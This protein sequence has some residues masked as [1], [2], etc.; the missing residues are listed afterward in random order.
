MRVPPQAEI[1]DAII[2]NGAGFCLQAANTE[3]TN[4]SGK[5][6][7]PGNDGLSSFDIE[8]LP[9]AALGLLTCDPTLIWR[10][11]DCSLLHRHGQRASCCHHRCTRATVLGSPGC[12]HRGQSW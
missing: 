1:K 10:L 4:D 5:A 3:L 7:F 9:L 8:V 2:H 12:P 6:F 11:L